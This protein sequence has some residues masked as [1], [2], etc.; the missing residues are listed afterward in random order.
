MPAGREAPNTAGLHSNLHGGMPLLALHSGLQLLEGPGQAPAVGGQHSVFSGQHL[1]QLVSI[2]T[3][4]LACLTCLS[5]C[6]DVDT[7]GLK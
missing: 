3:P 5:I 2:R 6:N 7:L 4:G 1:P